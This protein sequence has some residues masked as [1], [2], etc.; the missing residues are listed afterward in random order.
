M[1]ASLWLIAALATLAVSACGAFADH[2]SGGGGCSGD[3]TPP[4]LGEDNSGNA[5]VEDGFGINGVFF[6][7]AGF[8]QNVPTQA[9]QLGQPVE[10]TIRAYENEGPQRFSHAALMFGLKDEVVGGVVVESHSVV[11]SWNRAPGGAT[12]FDVVADEGLV[13]DVGV[14]HALIEDMFG[15][16]DN[17]TELRFKFT[18]LRDF[19]ASPIIVRTWDFDRNSWTNYFYNALSF[20][21]DAYE[22][23]DIEVYNPEK[24][25]LRIPG[26][27]KSNADLWSRGQIDDSV[28]VQG[29]KYCIDNRIMNIP[30]LPDYEPGGVLPF[31]DLKKGPQYY[32]DRYYAEPVYR[33]WFDEN[34]PG[35]TIEEAV[36]MPETAAIPSWIKNN[37]RLWAGGTLTDSEFA[38][39]IEHLVKSGVIIV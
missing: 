16:K 36:G 8:Q 39:G 28:F 24:D 34:F 19:D 5:F 31:V 10:I 23:G 38:A 6:D 1:Q 3:C 33:E 11:I 4:T 29:I 27:F 13:G 17:L 21:P 7:V 15:V 9:I 2:G 25:I 12:S 18:P 20:E 32:V 14:S 30:N 26:W 37:A 35:H 22:P